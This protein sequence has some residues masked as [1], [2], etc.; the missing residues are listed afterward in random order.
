MIGVGAGIATAV[1][2][3][4]SGSLVGLMW[5]GWRRRQRSQAHLPEAPLVP[6]DLGA[7][8][9]ALEDVHYVATSRTGD[10]LERIVVR[11]LAYRGRATVEVCDRGV[12]L[13]ISGERPCFIPVESI[14]EVAPAQATI[15]RAVERD[16]LVAIR[17]RLAPT[18]SVETYLRV[19]DPAARRRLFDALAP[20]IPATDDQESA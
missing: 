3:G 10:A 9:F 2:V 14:E 12:V 13:R 7:P 4:A 5:A 11:P 19:V 16:G 6:D 15:D 1:I 20:L 18:E 8:R 17:W